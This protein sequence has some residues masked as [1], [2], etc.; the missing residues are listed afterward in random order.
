MFWKY[1][2]INT[3]PRINEYTVS[4]TAE[5]DKCKTREEF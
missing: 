4:A 5:R 1:M 2:Y 3:M